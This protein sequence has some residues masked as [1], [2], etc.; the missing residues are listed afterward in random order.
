MSNGHGGKRAGAGRPKKSLSEK[1]AS[2]NPGK[3]PLKKLE[4]EEKK[5]QYPPPAAHLDIL[6]GGT[7]FYPAASLIYTQTVD[8]LR[9]TGCL[10]LISPQLVEDYALNTN[11]R[12]WAEY[13]VMRRGLVLNDKAKNRMVMNEFVNE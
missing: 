5:D 13:D 7:D 8:W 3:R 6:G 11:R 10:H 2:G 9:T 1:M 4:F 12:L